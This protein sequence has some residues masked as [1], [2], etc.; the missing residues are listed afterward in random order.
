MRSVSKSWLFAG[1]A[2]VSIAL[3]G[4]VS[5]NEYDMLAAENTM[6]RQQLSAESAEAQ[7][8]IASGEAKITRLQG[9]IKYTI[10]ADL[11]FAPGS[12]QLSDAGKRTISKMATRLAPTQQN[13]LVVN[14]YTDNVP[15]GE[16]LERKGISSNRELSQRRA[17]A[18]K[19]YM[20]SQGINPN[21]VEAVGHGAS[22]PVAEN[23]TA[24]GRSQN[25]RV[26]LTLGG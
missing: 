1:G 22:N 19:D 25:R 17:E 13:K 2:V 10:D 3:S 20:V 6:L 12:W 8:E 21:L 24:R 16:G 4:C 5:Q 18:V 9:A 7:A 23:D 26:E 14:G 11:L 15:I